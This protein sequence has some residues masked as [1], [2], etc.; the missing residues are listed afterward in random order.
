MV[1]AADIVGLYLDPPDNAMV[2]SIDEKPGMQ[3]LQRKTGYVY[4][5][6]G[7]I[8]RAFR[9]TYERNGTLNLFAALNIAF[10]LISAKTTKR[11]TRS[12]FLAFMDEVVTDHKDVEIHAILDNYCTHKHC[13]Q[14]LKEHPRV[15]FHYTPTSAS[16]MNQVEVWLSIFSRAALRG[17]SFESTDALASA[18]KSYLDEYNT[19]PKPFKWKKGEV[20][21]SQIRDTIA[22]C[23]N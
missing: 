23:R 12:D 2:I 4:T 8:V 16:W 9:S 18:V 20:K 11:K 13:D 1:K 22:T 7:K 6:S 21:G 3:A 15:H 14:W 10:G 19:H 17:A 5:D